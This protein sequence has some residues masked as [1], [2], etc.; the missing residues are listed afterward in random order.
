MRNGTLRNNVV[1]PELAGGLLE[2]SGALQDRFR[3]AAPF[4]H[5]VLEPFF[6]EP[7]LA[8]LR[9]ECA[10]AVMAADGGVVEARSGSEAFG[11]ARR[12]LDEIAR[13]RPFLDFMS[14]M[15]GIPGLVHDPGDPGNGMREHRHGQ[16]V[17]PHL[18]IR[19]AT[20]A[21][22]HRRLKLVVYLHQEW[23]ASWGGVLELFGDGRHDA[24]ACRIEPRLNR[25]VLLETGATGWHGFD[26]IYLPEDK[27][28]LGRQ[29]VALYFHAP[30]A[31]V[32]ADAAVVRRQG[33]LPAWVCAGTCLETRH[34]AELHAMVA[35][36]DARIDHL[37]REN[38]RLSRKRD[39]CA[40]P[41]LLSPVVRLL[42]RA[43][44]R[45]PR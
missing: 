30:R 32:P 31:A 34:V 6:A 25:A 9:N 5:V 39:A 11:P 24:A 4:A 15:T 18:D 21:H 35:E 19:S 27:R 44:R 23:R 3:H 2:R 38:L 7:F 36:L 41:G 40:H 26:A 8:R 33:Q 13:S 20:P 10:D 1:L 22:G 29:A 16:G 12:R 42:A 14:R 45:G 37:H 43:R 17:D 28:H